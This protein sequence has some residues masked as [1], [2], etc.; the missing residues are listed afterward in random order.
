MNI[1]YY[2]ICTRHPEF[3]DEY[4]KSHLEPT[5]EDFK[6]ILRNCQ[7]QDI[8]NK[9]S[10][11]Y[12][13]K[14]SYI[15]ANHV[16]KNV[17]LT[18]T[19]TIME[20]CLKYEQDLLHKIITSST[21]YPIIGSYD[22]LDIK[23]YIE[24]YPND[25]LLVHTL[26]DCNSDEIMYYL[27]TNNLCKNVSIK[28]LKG[29]NN[30]ANT[31]TYIL[32]NSVKHNIGVNVND[33]IECIEYCGYDYMYKLLDTS[34]FNFFICPCKEKV[35]TRGIVSDQDIIRQYFKL[36]GYNVDYLTAIKNK[37]L[38]GLTI[39]LR[40]KYD[41]ELLKKAHEFGITG[42]VM[43]VHYDDE[44][45]GKG[46]PC[47]IHVLLD[48]MDKLPSHLFNVY[49]VRIRYIDNIVRVLDRYNYYLA[50]GTDFSNVYHDGIMD[51]YVRYPKGVVDYIK[52]TEQDIILAMNIANGPRELHYLLK[53]KYDKLI[54]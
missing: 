40:R 13:I 21:S 27:V 22:E 5:Y 45:I 30:I 53:N 18:L 31:L 36:D 34:N 44:V 37:N 46:T 11:L 12:G 48:L 28:D 2:T 9:I 54:N 23:R 26:E 24:K 52:N 3:L 29:K 51:Y 20:F 14:E 47:Y 19:Q 38:G 41:M 49:L 15:V 25:K 39:K 43:L 32:I 4:H 35:L 42:I 1:T 6:M 50:T 17:D 10:R 8:L 7:D 16:E 33:V